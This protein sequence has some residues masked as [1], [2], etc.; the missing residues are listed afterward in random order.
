MAKLCILCWSICSDDRVGSGDA[1][2]DRR[3][4]RF[5]IR[6]WCLSRS[7]AR[8]EQPGKGGDEMDEKNHQM[9]HRRIVAGQSHILRMPE[10][11]L[12][13][14]VRLLSSKRAEQ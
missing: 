1:N 3:R 5:T 12:A 9:A 14:E 7:A 6:S 8:T 13:K 10:S 11:P 2:L 4:E